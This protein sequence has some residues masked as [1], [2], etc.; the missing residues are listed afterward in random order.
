M[1]IKITSFNCQ[2]AVTNICLIESLVSVSD[3][4]L[5]QETF[6]TSYNCN[7]LD[8]LGPNYDFATVPATRKCDVGRASGGLAIIWRKA[9]NLK[10]VPQYY[11]ERIMG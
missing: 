1:S 9:L 2:S 4:L 6:L 11:T 10:F 8:Q 3:V 5:L 7:V